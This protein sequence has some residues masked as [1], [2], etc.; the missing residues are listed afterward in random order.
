[1][2]QAQREDAAHQKPISADTLRGQL[3]I[4]SARARQLVKVVQSEFEEQVAAQRPACEVVNEMQ[5]AATMA[6]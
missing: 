1:M 3:G 2:A 4:G 6:A 5:E